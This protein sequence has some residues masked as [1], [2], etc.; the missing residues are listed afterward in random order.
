MRVAGGRQIR[1]VRQSA[2]HSVVLR[3]TF[4]PC[5]ELES[6]QQCQKARAILLRASYTKQTNTSTIW[7]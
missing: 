2:L 7:G 4:Y 6:D 1:T 5:R 3:D